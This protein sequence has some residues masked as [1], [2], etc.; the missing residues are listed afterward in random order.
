MTLCKNVKKS[1]INVNVLTCF[2][3]DLEAIHPT[4]EVM[5][6]LAY[7]H[8]KIESFDFS[9]KHLNLSSFFFIFFLLHPYTLKVKLKII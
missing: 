4:T 5:G 7:I 2:L 1:K 3:Q 8:K 6:V 9:L